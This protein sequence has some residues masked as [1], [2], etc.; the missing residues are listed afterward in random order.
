MDCLLF[1]LSAVKYWNF[2]RKCVTTNPKKGAFHYKAP[3]RMVWRVIRGMLPHK[4]PRGTKALERLKVFE[5]IPAP[6]DHMKRMVIPA[7]LRAL[8]LRPGRKFTQLSDLA[9]SFGWKYEKLIDQLESKRKARSAAFYARKSA[10]LKLR[11]KAVAAI[12]A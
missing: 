11:A 8:R 1:F 4:M 2:L 10:A 7:A 12:K 6:Y 9:T 3:S 5:G